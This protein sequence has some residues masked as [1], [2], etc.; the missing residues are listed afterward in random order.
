MATRDIQS[1]TVKDLLKVYS[2]KLGCM[3]GCNGK[4]WVT[5][6]SRA[7]A[8]KEQGYEYDDDEVSETQVLRILRLMQ[9]QAAKDPSS[10][11]YSNESPENFYVEVSPTRCYCIFLRKS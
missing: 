9:A 4:Y 2:G 7:E 10:V 5:P 6:E 1:V 3:C 8:G 11:E